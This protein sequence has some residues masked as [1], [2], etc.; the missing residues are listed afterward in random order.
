MQISLLI[1]TYFILKRGT[2]FLSKS[3]GYLIRIFLF[4][5]DNNFLDKEIF[6]YFYFGL[7]IIDW[8]SFLF[9]IFLQIYLFRKSQR[10]TKFFINFSATFVYMG[11]I[12]FCVLLASTHFSDVANSLNLTSKEIE[13]RINELHEH[14]PMLGHRGCRLG[15]SFPAIYEMQCRAIFEALIECKNNLLI[16]ILVSPEYLLSLSLKN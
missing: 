14:N 12:L 11:L 6:T 2:F 13:A 1:K 10:F 3:I 5:I 15:I 9:A 16:F 7:N 4:S 8:F